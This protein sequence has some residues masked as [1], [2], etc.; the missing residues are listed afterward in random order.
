MVTTEPPKVCRACEKVLLSIMCVMAVNVPPF[1]LMAAFIAPSAIMF[2]HNFKP[3]TILLLHI[4]VLRKF[5]HYAY[6]YL[7]LFLIKNIIVINNA[8]SS[9]TTIA[10][11]IPLIPKNIGNMR[12]TII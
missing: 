5:L 2:C 1:R 7:V 9:E 8:N 6:K 12:M 4:V 3:T 10:S 11:Q